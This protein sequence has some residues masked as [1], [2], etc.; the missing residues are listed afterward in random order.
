MAD[1]SVK[2]TIQVTDNGS[3]KKFDN[4]VKDVNKNLKDA[5]N[6]LR[7][8]SAIRLQNIS[9]AFQTISQNISSAISAINDLTGSYQE[10]IIAETQLQTVMNQRMGASAADVAAIKQLCAAQQQLGVIGDEVQLSGAQQMAT[11]LN[12]RSS[13]DTLIP[14]MNNLIAQH[15]GLNATQQSATSI[16]NM[17]GKAMMGQTDVLKE[18]GITFTEA[19][20][21]VLKYG[22]EEER[23][24]MLASVIQQNVGDMNTALAQTDA[25]QQIQLDNILGDIKES[26]GSCL[27]G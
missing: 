12:L 24:A 8:F 23:A 15:D 6:S 7:S 11:F 19:Q 1:N 2:Y 17:M 18:V 4:D 10:Q 22:T 16:G 13:L 21:A 20:A 9:Q 27:Q 3:L 5:N 14:A 25:G 26:L